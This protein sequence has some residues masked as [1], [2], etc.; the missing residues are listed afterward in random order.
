M[1]E[2]IKEIVRKECGEDDYKYH[3]VIVVKYAK[4][5]ADKLN[6]DKEVVEL[7]AWLHDITVQTDDANHHESGA[8]RAEEILRDFNYS[9]DLICKIKGCIISHRTSKAIEPDSIEAEIIRNA[10]AIAH[11]DILPVLFKYK[12][13]KGE[14]LKTA[15]QWVYDKIERDWSKKITLKEAKELAQE[16]YEAIK[17]VLDSLKEYV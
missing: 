15:F 2:R 5:L 12:L 9:D 3:V 6:A 8:K 4:M 14:D 13:D 10:D 16:K 7:A 1:D 17:L 11:F